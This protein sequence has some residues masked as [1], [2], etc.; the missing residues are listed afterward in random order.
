MPVHCH[1][2]LPSMFLM[3]LVSILPAYPQETLLLLLPISPRSGSTVGQG[4]AGDV[5]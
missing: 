1:S 4:Q 5:W 3:P 2:E